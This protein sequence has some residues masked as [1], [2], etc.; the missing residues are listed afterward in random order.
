MP[1]DD[2]YYYYIRGSRDPHK[3][4]TKY[5]RVRDEFYRGWPGLKEGVDIRRVDKRK[6]SAEDVKKASGV[7]YT[8]PE[9]KYYIDRNRLTS[10]QV[11]PKEES[12]DVGRGFDVPSPPSISADDWADPET[13][14]M[15]LETLVDHLDGFQIF[16][17]RNKWF[18]QQDK[19]SSLV[20]TMRT[21]SKSFPKG[22]FPKDR[23]ISGAEQSLDEQE[24]ASGVGLEGEVSAENVAEEKKKE[25][26]GLDPARMSVSAIGAGIGSKIFDM[27]LTHPPEERQAAMEALKRGA[28]YKLTPEEALK[29]YQEGGMV[30]NKFG[31]FLVAQVPPS[32]PPFYIGVGSPTNFDSVDDVATKV[33]RGISAPEG[34]KLSIKRQ[35][36]QSIVWRFEKSGYGEPFRVEAGT[37][38]K[39]VK[40]ADQLDL[41][42]MFVQASMVDALIKEAGIMSRTQAWLGQ[43]F[44][45]YYTRAQFAPGEASR[46]KAGF[47]NWANYL[48]FK[49]GKGLLE[50]EQQYVVDKKFSNLLTQAK[51]LI[52]NFYLMF[53]SSSPMQKKLSRAVEEEKGKG[54]AMAAVR[55]VLSPSPGAFK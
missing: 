21:I 28:N 19:L 6:V 4:I 1:I 12:A 54:G 13:L 45:P 26:D 14:S 34:F 35:D 36:P 50:I 52:R 2:A 9:M 30:Y 24:V 33:L 27:L 49:F 39:I 41:M 51:K 10:P 16:L 20:E 3:I 42:G 37:I 48:V 17:H 7:L 46:M 11:V 32:S 43:S 8:L 29:H 5:D 47:K 38:N 40:I 31:Y 22:W 15:N 23:I 55:R 53:G 18:T 44:Q 25:K